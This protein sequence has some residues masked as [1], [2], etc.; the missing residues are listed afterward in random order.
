MISIDIGNA[1]S[2]YFDGN[3]TRTI[4][5]IVAPVTSANNA[6][7]GEGLIGYQGEIFHVGENAKKYEMYS[8]LMNQDKALS[9]DNCLLLLL[10]L[11]PPQRGTL[12]ENTEVALSFPDMVT[13][14][15]HDFGNA[16][17]G[18]KLWNLDRREYKTIIRIAGTYQE[19]FGSWYM[20][21]RSRSIPDSGY[22][23]VIDIGGGTTLGVLID[24]E[25][26]EVIKSQTYSRMGVVSLAE[27]MQGDIDLRYENSGDYISTDMILDGI[28]KGT[29]QLGVSGLIFKDYYEK[30]RKLWWKNMFQT[31]IMS[32][33]ANN[34]RSRAINA[35]IV[36]GGGAEVVRPFV[37]RAMDSAGMGK[38]FCIA[39]NPLED[40]VRGVWFHKNDRR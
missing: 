3:K 22:S 38:I 29:F 1:Y 37:E 36:T 11:L 4:R 5:S 9:I 7:R 14:F 2:L 31:K 30:Y 23:L 17:K 32:S 6:R 40:N 8:M 15:A 18:A 25:S 28:E 13:T 24:N 16:A 20:M 27:M 26:G 10:A 33:F 12:E 35:I 34:F 39:N 19:G 21:K